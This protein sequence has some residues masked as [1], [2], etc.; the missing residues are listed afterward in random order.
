MADFEGLFAPA[1]PILRQALFHRVIAPD[2]KAGDDDQKDYYH[3]HKDQEGVAPLQPEITKAL[4]AEGALRFS[5]GD[6][7]PA[8]CTAAV[9]LHS[10]Q[11]PFEGP[12]IISQAGRELSFQRGRS[13]HPGVDIAGNPIR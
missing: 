7:L 6:C 8:F 4:R 11:S 12:D 3:E 13:L 2:G 10:I 5:P 1:V 9:G